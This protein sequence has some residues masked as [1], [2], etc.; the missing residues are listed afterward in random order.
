[1][2]AT[3]NWLK[4]FVDIPI[5]AKELATRL[6]FAGLKI[7]GTESVGG[8]TVFDFEIAVNRP[9]WLSV[10]GIARETAALLK[11]GAI[12][13]PSLSLVNVRKVEAKE[14]QETFGGKLLRIV[15]ED[16]DLCPQ[17]CGQII[18]GVK[19][20][21]SPAWITKKLEACG[22]RPISN[23]VDITN[24]VMLELG[25]PLH[26]FDYDKISKGTIIVRRAHNEKLLM[27]DD[28]ERTL[29]DPMLAIADPSGV[30]AVGGVMG[31]KPTEV[32]DST[33]TLLLESAYFTPA[34]IRKTAKR[35]EMST[36]ASYRFER[37]VDPNLQPLTCRRAAYL[38]QEIAGG[39]AYDVLQV[40]G[41]KFTP[42]EVPLR[43]SRIERVLGI[44]IAKEFVQQTLSLLGFS[45]KDQKVWQ[46]PSYRVDIQREID[47]IEEIARHHGYNNF[48]DTLPETDRKHQADYPTFELEQRLATALRAARF[49]EAYTYSFT[50]PASRYVGN[51]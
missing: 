47:L 37:G 29:T 49:D 14:G 18:T 24:L 21:P 7:E 16:P 1:M 34:S 32:T 8:D 41:K 35:L 19:I 50:S 17:Y 11:A 6:T 36:D 22:V 42:V 3:Y 2:K 44:P 51:E 9:D 46:V 33:T 40:S 38:F 39:K 20:G 30:V 26:A 12:R 5:P 13:T 43:M 10:M 45:T 28:K 15:L 23:V 27:I 25:Q 48:P 4:E 31:G